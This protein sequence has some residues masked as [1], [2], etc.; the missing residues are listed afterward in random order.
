MAQFVAYRNDVVGNIKLL[1]PYF[2]ADTRGK[3]KRL[4]IFKKHNIDLNRQEIYPM[5]TILDCFKDFAQ[6]LGDMNVFLIGRSGAYEMN[7]PQVI[8]FKEIIEQMNIFYHMMYKLND[9][10]MYDAQSKTFTE[11]IGNYSV[12]AY[13]ENKKEM[14]VRCSTP[15]PSKSDEGMLT[16]LF[17]KYKPAHI[18]KVQVNLDIHQERR[19]NGADSCTFIVNWK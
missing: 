7:F 10:H 18:S 14:I 4:E 3:E 19:S 15:F 17:E 12:L 9:K 8:N 2:N 6:L 11:G 16:G 5:Q 1:T 13:D